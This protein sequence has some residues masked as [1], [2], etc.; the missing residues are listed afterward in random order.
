MKYINKPD[1]ALQSLTI[2]QATLAIPAVFN[3][4]FDQHNYSRKGH[5]RI[6]EKIYDVY[7]IDADGE[8]FTFYEDVTSFFGKGRIILNLFNL[9][10]P[11]PNQS[12]PLSE[13]I[14]DDLPKEKQFSI[15]NKVTVQ[16]K[17]YSSNMV[18]NYIAAYY[19]Q[20]NQIDT[21][22]IKEY[23]KT[24]G[25]PVLHSYN[26]YKLF[27]VHQLCHLMT[28][29]DFHQTEVE[30][31][32]DY[33]QPKIGIECIGFNPITNRTHANEFINY[34]LWTHLPNAFNNEHE[35]HAFKRSVYYGIVTEVFTIKEVYDAIH[36][37]NV[38]LP[39]KKILLQLCLELP[40]R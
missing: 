1:T 17:Q 21:T 6:S 4:L 10:V 8:S 19:P 23:N 12:I 5:I 3:K 20:R 15:S 14:T 27:L 13:F 40:R 16:F 7:E 31:K 36:L 28:R 39:T 26:L 30:L 22:A 37:S 33:Y 38:E 9:D 34:T 35:R 32:G 25:F 24:F 18:S 11:F 29:H 2:S